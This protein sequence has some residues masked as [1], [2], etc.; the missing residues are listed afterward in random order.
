M[1]PNPISADGAASDWLSRKGSAAGVAG[2]SGRIR[3][4][5]GETIVGRLSINPECE[6]EILQDGEAEAFLTADSAETLIGLLGGDKHPVVAR[7]QGRIATGGDV[8]FVIRTFLG[9][10][11]GSPWSH[12]PKSKT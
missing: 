7:L 4:N 5:I 12:F 1:Q 11:A 8:A 10:Q 9:L 2:L 6:V 3:L